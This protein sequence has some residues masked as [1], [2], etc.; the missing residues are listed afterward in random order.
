MNS[1]RP[2]F[3]YKKRHLSFD[4]KAMVWTRFVKNTFFPKCFPFGGRLNHRGSILGGALENGQAEPN[5]MKRSS[6]SQI[7]VLAQIV[8]SLYLTFFRAPR[9]LQRYLCSFQCA[10][11]TT[12]VLIRLWHCSLRPD[13]TAC[14]SFSANIQE[15]RQDSNAYY[16]LI[17]LR[18]KLR[19]T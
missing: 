5:L 12:Q 10:S 4:G 7:S 3:G 11:T 8:E 18:T 16:C 2:S 15:R 6:E 9:S 17:C 1:P 14:K 19:I 13:K